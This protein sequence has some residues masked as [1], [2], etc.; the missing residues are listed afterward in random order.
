MSIA[1][2]VS[3]TGALLFSSGLFAEVSTKG[4]GE[5]NYRDWSKPSPEEME[6]AKKMAARAALSRWASSQGGS[7]LKN[8]ET[9]RDHLESNLPQ[10]V[11]GTSVLSEQTD[12][13]ARS[14]RVVLKVILD[15]VKIK[16]RISDASVVS[17]VDAADK[18]YMTFVFV[19]RR[20]VS[21]QRFDEKIYK[22]Q[23]A[24]NSETGGESEQYGNAGGQFSSETNTSQKVVTGGSA[25]QQSDKIHYAVTSSREINT[26]M[27][28]IFSSSGFEVV[29]A[30]FLEE[31]T[32]GLLSVEAFKQDFSV[33]QDVS[34]ATRRD[35]VKGAKMVD[36]PYLAVGTLDIG[37][38]EA[39]SASGLVRVNV[40]VTGKMLSLEKRFPK[41]IASVGPVVYA[42]IGPN[43]TVAEQNALKMASE[44]AAN[45]LVNQLNAKAVM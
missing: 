4:V 2:I 39:D 11:L 14:Y 15:D 1:R 43:Q 12:E 19:A 10:Y 34:G 23:D 16:N 25:T 37:V 32:A 20:Q 28:Q 17:N 7:F 26:A 42:G 33:G 3:L 31:E 29:D 35:A 8:Y 38:K 22:R 27:S 45:E 13:D 40:I 6:A 41:T 44:A 9:V 5:I 24:S 36:I 30:D 18:S 21:V